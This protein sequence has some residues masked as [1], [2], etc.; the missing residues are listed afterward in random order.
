MLPNCHQNVDTLVSGIN[1]YLN[2]GEELR[3]P[4]AFK[5]MVESIESYLSIN[6]IAGIDYRKKDCAEMIK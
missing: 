1:S 2:T 4:S 6:N 3:G 5:K